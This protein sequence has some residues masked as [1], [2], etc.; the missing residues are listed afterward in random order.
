VRKI[1]SRLHAIGGFLALGL[2][3]VIAEPDLPQAS[4]KPTSEA[5]NFEQPLRIA[6]VAETNNERL[7]GARQRGEK[8]REPAIRNSNAASGA[9]IVSRSENGSP[10]DVNTWLIFG[11]TEGS[12][13]GRKGEQALFHESLVR[14]SGRNGRF[15]GWDNSWGVGYSVSDQAFVWIGALS[16][17]ERCGDQIPVPEPRGINGRPGASVLALLAAF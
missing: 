4:N 7:T 13:V 6:D 14:A 16:S 8:G 12:D 15:V 9:N 1:Y 17:F 10:D 3:S 11:F 5:Q 2:T